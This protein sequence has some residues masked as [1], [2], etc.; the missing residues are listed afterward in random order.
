ML[1]RLLRLFFPSTPKRL[2]PP[3]GGVDVRRLMEQYSI[4]EL[5]EFTDNYFKQHATNITHYLKKPFSHI[6]EAGHSLIAFAE[7]LNGLRPLPGMRLLDFGAGTCW[8][9][10]YFADLRLD[11]IACDVSPTALEIGKQIFARNP[12][13]D[14]PF[15][16]EFL[17]FNGRR[18]AL[19]DDHVDRIAC[20]DTFHHV[21]NPRAVLHELARVL[22]P[23][24]IAGFSEPGPNHS[25]QPASQYEMKNYKTIENDIILEEIWEWAGEAGFT[26]INVAVFNSAPFRL[27]LDEFNK[28]LKRG[29][30]PLRSYA[31]HVQRF[32]RSRRI[33]FLYKGEPLAPDSRDGSGLAC[34]LNVEL[35]SSQ[36]PRNDWI[37]GVVS[38]H[39]TGKGRWLPSDALF[40][41]VRLGVHLKSSDGQLLNRDFARVN[42]PEKRT[43]EP[44]EKTEIPFRFR[45][46]ARN[47]DYILEFDMVS[48][49][50]CWFEVNGSKVSV[51]SIKVEQPS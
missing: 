24:G 2:P 37:E 43:I 15:K 49:N 21:P 25:R 11:V 18:L 26:D 14:T 19:P 8:A 27:S 33:F 38:A 36:V 42:I 9:T 13:I 5:N 40:G 51:S 41:P 35:K 47:G 10:R 20:M 31:K 50:V 1:K 48:E 39:N 29:S 46:P 28:L 34:E 12:I 44:G 6:E 22:K 30:T 23:G 4:E 45:A 16:P 7:V 32:V 3:P 17:V